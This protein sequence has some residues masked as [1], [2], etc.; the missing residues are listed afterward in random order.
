MTIIDAHVHVGSWSHADFLG[1]GATLDQT[2]AVMTASGVQGCA[3][4]P[5]DRCDNAGLLAEAAAAAGRGVALWFIAWVR[6][7]E[8][9]AAGGVGRADLDWVEAHRGQMTGIKIHPSLSRMRVTDDGFA[10]ALDLAEAR[11]LVVVVHCGRWQ[12]MASYRF[13]V[14]AARR[15]PRARFLLAHAGGD[16]PPLATAAAELV[17]DER[18]DNVWFDFAGLREH[19]VVE[20]NVALIG[21]ERYLMGSDFNLAHPLMYIGAVRGMRLGDEQRARILGENARALLGEPLR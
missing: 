8:V 4:M 9:G 19:W 3:I 20:R 14:E 18:V 11:D 2:L 13:A 21:A 5:T 10:P 16:T 12:E 17:R 15:H 1:R 7:A 6:P